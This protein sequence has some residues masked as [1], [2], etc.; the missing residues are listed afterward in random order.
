MFTDKFS[1]LAESM[2]KRFS[3]LWLQGKADVA[4]VDGTKTWNVI[5]F[6]LMKGA[7]LG[8]RRAV[9]CGA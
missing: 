5:Q 4:A 7:G 9:P 8:G 2:S 3:N 1:Q 6:N